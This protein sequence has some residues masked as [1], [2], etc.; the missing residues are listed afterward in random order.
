MNIELKSP[1]QIEKMRVAGKLAADVLTMITPY[2][3]PGVSTEELDDICLDYIENTQHAISAC[4]GYMGYPKA[5]CIS[6][7]EVVCHGIPS[8]KKLHEGDIVNIDITVI[9]DG[10][11]GDT[12]MMFIVGGKTYPRNENLCKCAQ[13]SLYE[14]IKVVRPGANLTEI[15]S[16]IQKIADRYDFSIVRDYCGHGLGLKF[17][18]D[19]QVLH[20]RNDLNCI[21]EPGMTF[22]IEPMINAGT[23]KCKVNRKD[24]WTVTTAD[25]QPSAQY[26]HTI[27]VTD[28][29]CEVL[30]L[31]E[32]EDF[33]RIITH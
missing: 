9:K 8:H 20:Y 13:E 5:T 7:N 17:H 18:E 4:L 25:K 1:S 28:N 21:L 32:D 24:G 29:G 6:I 2:V 33:P 31:R 10:Y 16:T 15:G 19:P 22:T 23:W 3:K 14:A 11:H 27:L 30:T 12:S 26:E